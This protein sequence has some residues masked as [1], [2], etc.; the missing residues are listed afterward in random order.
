M[1]IPKSE[2]ARAKRKTLQLENR[3]KDEDRKLN[4]AEKMVYDFY[5]DI[6]KQNDKTNK[7]K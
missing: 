7:K 5:I 4:E 1:G 6:L 2:I 3:M